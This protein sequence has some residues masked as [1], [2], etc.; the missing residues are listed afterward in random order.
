MIIGIIKR[1]KSLNFVGS[2]KFDKKNK[3]ISFEDY[4]HHDKIYGRN[5]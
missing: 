2:F 3:I 4:D 5:K 1:V